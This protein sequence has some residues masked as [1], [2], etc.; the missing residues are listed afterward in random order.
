MA[1]QNLKAYPH[2]K[3][4]MASAAEAA[5]NVQEA[6]QVTCFMCAATSALVARAVLGL[7]W[8]VRMIRAQGCAVAAW[9]AGLNRL[10]ELA[11]AL[12]VL[13]AGNVQLLSSGLG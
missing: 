10:F 11:A 2:G 8:A 7:A 4:G 6:V 1:Y 9:I 3:S 5:H 12:E 13:A